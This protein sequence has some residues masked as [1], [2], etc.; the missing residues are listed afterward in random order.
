MYVRFEGCQQRL[1]PA[2]A[3]L[4]PAGRCS[5]S[6][7]PEQAKADRNLKRDDLWLDA[8]RLFE[9]ITAAVSRRTRRANIACESG[10]NIRGTPGILVSFTWPRRSIVP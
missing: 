8:R 2:R 3:Q 9:M 1:L 10:R 6:Q 7:K 5:S 4:T